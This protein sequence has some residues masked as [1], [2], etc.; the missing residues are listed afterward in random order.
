[1]LRLTRVLGPAALLLFAI[2]ALVAGLNFGGGAAPQLLQ[3]PGAVVRWGLPVSKLFVN[4]GAAAMI[5][6]LVLS[7]FALSP[8][9]PEFN[10]A[11]DVAAAG[12]AVFTVA[13][14]FTGFFT[15]LSVTGA[16]LSLD[17]QFGASLSQF[18][19]QIELGQAWLIT[20]LV[21]AA[22]TVLCFAVRN[23]TLLV[24]VT[25]LAVAALIPMA[26]QGHAA[27]TAGHNAAVTSLGLHI[28]AAAAWLGGLITV[29][30]LREKLVDRRLITVL[31]RY[32]T[33]ALIAFLVLTISGVATS[34][35]QLGSF[36][37]LLSSYGL[38]LLAKVAALIVLGVFGVIQRGYFI[39]RMQRA[40]ASAASAVRWF[41]GFVVA[42]LAFMGIASGLAVALART[43]KPVTP[44][45]ELTT[46]RTPAEL[47]TGE[48]LPPELNFSRYF[49]E[50]NIDLIWLLVCAFGIFFYLAGVW[51]LTKR[52]DS[53]PIYRTVL[54]IAGMIAL[55]Y[56]SS[57]GVAVYGKFLFSTHML[58]AHGAD[59]GDSGAAGARRPRDAGDARHP[60]P[61]GRQPR[62][63]RVDP[64]RCALPLRLDHRQPDRRGRALRRLALGVLL[65]PAV[66]L[67]D[68]RPH[69]PPV[70]DGALPA[71]RLPL[72][73]VTDRHRPGAV[74]PAVPVPPAPAARHHGVPRLLRARDHD[75]NRP[76][77]GRLVRRDGPR[78]GLD[79]IA[80]QQ[81]GG[82]IAWS[83]GEIPTLALAITVAI[84]WSRSDAKETKRSDR[85]ADRT[86]EAELNAY[87]ENLARI[88]ERD[89][90]G[91]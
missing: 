65:Q 33:V 13:A 75:R 72:R 28:A 21:G 31:T 66:Q 73:A 91:R 63:A 76:A 58:A 4:L 11:L 40:G 18:L 19:T 53:W 20:T 61:Q 24:F 87:N 68:D 90:A 26:Q 64:A 81:M 57:G 34:I 44:G 5:G 46:T 55:F 82:G 35:L 3:D 6:A 27:G 47:L 74:P 60:A 45:S 38:I 86:H 83:V 85:N 16:A 89:K 22:V 50:W 51:R 48:K 37:N 70:D 43:P 49:T 32:S 78:L 67:G 54:W 15:Y 62:A 10:S 1:M 56:V 69:R 59:D 14:A 80:D 30:L 29:V 79:A 7:C 77:A 39:E 9:Q 8:K 36:E 12:A 52:G 23:H 25:V 2:A 17:A 88:A 84:Q 71:H 41:W 42:E